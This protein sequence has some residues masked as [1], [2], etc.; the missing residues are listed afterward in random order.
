MKSTLDET[1]LSKTINIQNIEFNFK[2]FKDP[3]DETEENILKIL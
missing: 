1:A 2:F 3:T